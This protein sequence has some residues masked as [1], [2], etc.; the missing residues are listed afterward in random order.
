MLTPVQRELKRKYIKYLNATESVD[1]NMIVDCITN[2]IT[3]EIDFTDKVCLDLGGNVGGFTKVAIDGGAKAVYTVECDIRN[4]E[5][6]VE[7]FKDEPKANIIH[8]AVSDSTAQTIRIFKGN[9]QQAHCSVSIMKRSKFADYDEVTNVHISTLL[10]KYQPDI[11]KIDIEGAEYQIIEFV[12]A[13]QPEALFVELHMGKVKQYA[14]PTLERLSAIYPKQHI[15]ELIVF[16]S[17]AGYDCWF[18]K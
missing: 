10:K 14:Q 5:K 18:T 3:P 16:Q 13:Y 8:A 2:Y 6:M 1:K 17:I 4:Y 7:S 12:E 9:S 11:I 15:K